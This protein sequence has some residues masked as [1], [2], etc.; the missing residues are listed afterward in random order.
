M[1]GAAADGTGRVPVG[2]GGSFPSSVAVSARTEVVSSGQHTQGD[3][4][5]QAHHAPSALV[6]PHAHDTHRR[7]WVCVPGPVGED[8]RG[9]G[10][11]AGEE[12]RTR[13]GFSRRFLTSAH[14]SPPP[15]YPSLPLGARGRPD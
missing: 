10:S 4:D 14:H 11:Q 8:G 9:G 7:A 12:A 15:T 5:T 13:E 2:T 1:V 6:A 3:E